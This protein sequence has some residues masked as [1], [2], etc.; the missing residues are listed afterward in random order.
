MVKDA[1]SHIYQVIGE[2][3]DRGDVFY[4]KALR[5]KAWLFAAR[6]ALVG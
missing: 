5:K 6:N 2:C 4:A 3:F 1:K